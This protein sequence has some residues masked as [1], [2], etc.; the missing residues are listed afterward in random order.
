MRNDVPDRAALIA[1]LT[2]FAGPLGPFERA[3]DKERRR[4]KWL[5]GLDAGA[6]DPLLGILTERPTPR[7]SGNVPWEDLEWTLVAALAAAGSHDPHGFL[8]RIGPLLASEPARPALLDVFGELGLQDGIRWLAPLIESTP[9]TPDEL[10]RLACSLG[11][12]GGTA[13]R[14]LLERIRGLPG[15]DAAEVRQEIET[16]LRGMEE[17]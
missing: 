11:E 12:I 15:A 8:E 13:A 7:E 5:A 3:E 14:G 4:E 6:I 17:P 2:D 16:A 10:V 9:L 1:D